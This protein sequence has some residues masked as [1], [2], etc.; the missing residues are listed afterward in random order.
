[1]REAHSAADDSV[2][3]QKSAKSTVRLR[4]PRWWQP[5]AAAL[6]AASSVGISLFGYQAVTAEPEHPLNIVVDEPFEDDMGIGL[7]PEN[8]QAAAQGHYTYEPFTM[9]VVSRELE[10]SEWVDKELGGA[11]LMLSTRLFRDVEN[12]GPFT[13]EEFSLRWASMNNNAFAHTDMIGQNPYAVQDTYTNNLVLGHAPNAVVGAALTAADLEFSGTVRTPALWVPLAALPLVGAVGLMWLWQRARGQYQRTQ[14]RFSDAKLTLAR[15]VLEL[16]ALEIRYL[17]AQQALHTASENLAEDQALRADWESLHSGSL[18][19]ARLEHQLDRLFAGTAAPA[20]VDQRLLQTESSGDHPG[21]AAFTYFV[22][23]TDVLK[24]RADAL[25]SASELR[26]GHAGSRSVL[27]RLALP[28]IQAMDELMRQEGQRSELQKLL[29]PYREK[30]LA[31]SSEVQDTASPPGEN[32]DDDAETAEIQRLVADRADLL[33][34]WGQTEQDMVADLKRWRSELPAGSFGDRT[35]DLG[36]RTDE[37]VRARIRAFTGGQHESFNA[38]RRTLGLGHGAD[39]G[40]LHSVE[41]CLELLQARSAD[42]A[43]TAGTLVVEDETNWWTRGSTLGVVVPILISLGAGLIAAGQTDSS[44]P[45]GLVLEGDQELAQ[46][47]VMGDLSTVAEHRSADGVETLSHAETLD[48]DYVREQMERRLEFTGHRALLPEHLELTVMLLPVDEYLDYE[49][50]LGEH[51]TRMRF[52][53]FDLV[54]AFAQIKQEAADEYPEVLDAETGEVAWGQAL[55]P[56]W[57]RED[58]SYA[59]SAALAGDI[60]TGQHSR[61]GASSYQYL[62]PQIYDVNDHSRMLG[63]H[64]VWEVGQLGTAMEYNHQEFAQVS[65]SQVFWLSSVTAWGGLQMLLILGGAV[66]GQ[67]ERRFGSLRAQRQLGQLRAQLNEL[68]LGL[69]LSRVDMVAVIGGDSGSGGRAEQADQRLYE[70]GLV[71]ALRQVQ[72]MERL[73][74]RQKRGDQWVNQVEDAQRVIDGLTARERDVS[75]RAQLLLDSQRG[76]R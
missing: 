49:L 14:Q 33:Q 44:T 12:E 9:R 51:V 3:P 45:Y 62:S 29:Q 37:R 8:I 23:Q 27:D 34:R 56:V 19:L 31:L 46:L 20:D 25:A 76:V 41:Q 64:V 13:P 43:A 75:A 36:E 71:T 68:S 24:E 16:D 67:L 59:V 55:L 1:M 18:E 70:A 63:D 58:G 66:A 50:E 17:T 21:A 4:K 65:G 57:V 60:S 35:Q 72:A 40:P 52:D 38:L 61:L 7:T 47:Q 10:E 6:L 22:R 69:D 15:V 73:P 54:E 39:T 42:H 53:F 30:F 5:V 48:L 2:T 26:A 11:D 32:N 28:L 74:R